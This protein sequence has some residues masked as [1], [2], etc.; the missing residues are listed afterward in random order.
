MIA[1][2]IK[3]DIPPRVQRLKEGKIKLA[4]H[5]RTKYSLPEVYTNNII[6][7]GV[8]R[9]VYQLNRSPR[10]KR[11]GKKVYIYIYMRHFFTVY[12]GI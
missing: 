6:F 5:I 4:Q 2:S 7:E 1:A 10:G 9:R 12:T 11:K 3:D 8:W